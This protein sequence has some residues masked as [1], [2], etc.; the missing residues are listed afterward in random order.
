[1]PP[2]LS[3]PATIQQHDW[4]AFRQ[5]D[6]MEDHWQR[7]GWRPGRRSY[8]WMLSFHDADGVRQLAKQCQ[9]SIHSP[10]FDVVPLD[11]LH[12][13]VGRIGFTDEVAKTAAL[14]AASEARQ[15]R[16][17]HGP[18]Q[19]TVGP[20]AASRG[21]LRFS[22]APWAP[23]LALHGQLTDATREILRGRTVMDTGTFRPHLSIAYANS[24]VNVASLLP[25]LER[26]R[27]FGTTN[28][29]V[30]SVDLVEL[31]R[32]DKTYRFETLVAVPFGDAA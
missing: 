7:P 31:W 5:L 25:L 18:F 10:S 32:H 16:Q 17:Q 11:A 19:L 29:S 13:T 23:L 27:S 24:T 21:A 22:V 26:L 20:L 30:C 6:T 9:V 4:Q 14:A 2:N 12:L 15:R 3:D 8:H 1:M 28:A